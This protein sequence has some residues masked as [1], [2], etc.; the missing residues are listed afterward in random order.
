MLDFGALPPE[1]NSATMYSGPGSG[2]LMTAASAWNQL[3]V[4]LNSAALG[5]DRVITALSSEQ[6]LGPASAAMAESAA[7]YVAWM[8]TAAAQAEQAAGQARAAAAAYETALSAT[9]PVP[10]VAANRAALAEALSYNVFGQYTGEIAAI[11]AQYAEM[12]AQD[13]NAMYGYAGQSAAAAY[14]T[15]FQAAPQITSPTAQATQAAATTSA[16]S[17][18][19]ATSQSALSQLISGLPSQLNNLS[20]PV[21][22]ASTSSSD[23]LM[24]EIWFLLSGQT[25]LPTN[26]GTLLNGISPFSSL[27][28]NT[29]GLPYFSVGMGN[30]GIQMAKTMGLLNGVGGGAAAGAAAGTP[31]T[32]LSSLGGLLGGGGAGGGAVSA[33]VGNADMIGDIAVPP[34][35]AQVS[36]ASSGAARVAHHTMTPAAH[37][38]PGNMLGGMPLAGPHGGASAAGPKYGFRPKVMARPPFAG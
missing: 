32:G 28:Y 34:N 20:S 25:A 7:P 15:P 27:W 21:S 33:G 23:S 36:G 18:S 1:V 10:V 30:F 6:W 24:S 5:Y 11:E 19:A 4:E 29:E 26:A 22:A 9:V 8:N 31:T 17:T 38:G 35:W 37:E 2:S 13:A 12:W 16:T 14:V 3:A